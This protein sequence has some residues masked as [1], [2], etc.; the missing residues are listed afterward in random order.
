MLPATVVSQDADEGA[1]PAHHGMAVGEAAFLRPRS[2]TGVGWRL[3][4][5]GGCQR[6]YLKLFDKPLDRQSGRNVRHRESKDREGSGL[7]Q[8]GECGDGIG[9]VHPEIRR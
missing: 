4:G 9:M 8:P 2:Q 7:C 5:K 3:Q 6:W 1:E